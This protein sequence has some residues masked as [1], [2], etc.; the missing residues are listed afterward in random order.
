MTATFRTLIAEKIDVN[1][2]YR[3]SKRFL[4]KKSAELKRK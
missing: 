3:K 4:R 1:E 2:M